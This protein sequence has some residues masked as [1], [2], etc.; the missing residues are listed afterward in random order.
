MQPQ[1]LFDFYQINFTGAWVIC[2]L[3]ELSSTV[4]Q[5]PALIMNAWAGRR[6]GS[7]VVNSKAN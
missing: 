5:E 6:V 2:Q 3:L 1:D 7:Q 4:V